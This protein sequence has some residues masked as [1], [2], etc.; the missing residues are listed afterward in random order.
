MRSTM[1]AIPLLAACTSGGD[2]NAFYCDPECADYYTIRAIDSVHAKVWSSVLSN[3]PPGEDGTIAYDNLEIPCIA[4][5]LKVT[6][7]ATPSTTGAVAVDLSVVH[8]GCKQSDP[9]QAEGYTIT[10][11]GTIGW[12]GEFSEGGARDLSYQSPELTVSG[13]VV[14]ATTDPVSVD[15]TCTLKVSLTS[16]SDEEFK[17]AGAWCGRAI[18]VPE[19]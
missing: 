14:E 19:T 7:T 11:T 18:V 9:K 1:A 10:T 17:F 15:E 16:T 8:E 3:E 4:G 2:S 6:G 12:A 13:T 5:Q